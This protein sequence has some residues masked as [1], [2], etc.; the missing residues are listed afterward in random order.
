M[1]TVTSRTRA[2]AATE[3]ADR[4]PTRRLRPRRNRSGAGVHVW[5]ATP[6]T[7][8][9]IGATIILS[10]FPLYWM[11]VVAS[12]D[13]SAATTFPPP[14]TPGGN[15]ADN[16]STAI[17]DDSSNLV[18]G[19]INSFIVSGTVAFSVVVIS[20]LAGFAFAK[21]RFKGSTVLL[22]IILLTMA[23][24]L[25]HIGI[26]PLYIM[27]IELGWVNTLQAVILPFLVNGFGI[28]LMRQY[29]IQAVPDELVEAARIDG[30]STLRIYWNIVLPA[31][32][33]GIA[34]LGLLTFMQNWNEFL[35]PLIALSPDNPTVQ[36]AIQQLTTGNYSADYSM[37][38]TG[39][40]LSILPLLIVFIAFGKQIVGG[41]ME[42]GVK[43]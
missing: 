7:R 40:L 32:R 18:K 25:Q 42:G 36:V 21:L 28:F 19:L 33:P 39:T 14:M 24:P 29:T 10:I 34:V 1:S 2:D 11:I 5:D 4:R 20:T 27:M 23:V 6:L 37:I 31:V 12:R 3:P 22:A 43:A 41:I 35:W 9:A 15:L 30:A 13:A 8:I 26:V 17:N 16:V 38:F